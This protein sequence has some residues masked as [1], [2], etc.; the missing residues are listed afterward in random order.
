MLRFAILIIISLG[1][2]FCC[3]GQNCTEMPAHFES[4]RKAITYIKKSDF[5]LKDLI[6]TSKSSWV[7][8]ASYYSCNN[9][10]GY[11]IISTDKK[12]YLHFGLPLSLWLEFKKSPS[13]CDFYNKNIKGKFKFIL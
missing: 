11:F 7:R 12:E 3:N 4:Y 8:S 13:F 2:Q 10:Y 5:K 6:N 1:L 9:K